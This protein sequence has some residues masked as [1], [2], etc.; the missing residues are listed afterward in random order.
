MIAPPILPIDTPWWYR[1]A[2]KNRDPDL[3]VIPARVLTPDNCTALSICRGSCPVQVEC[4]ADARTKPPRGM[5]AGGV[6]WNVHGRPWARGRQA[7]RKPAP[8]GR[9]G[10]P[11]RD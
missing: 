10:S 4:L 3:W 9:R 11:L 8:V 6:A 7:S 1:A 5:V 2:C